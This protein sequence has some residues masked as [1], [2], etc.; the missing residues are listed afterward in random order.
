[1]KHPQIV[2]V[3]TIIGYSLPP[4]RNLLNKKANSLE[5]SHVFCKEPVHSDAGC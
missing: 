5:N 3:R 4:V 1:M 2:P